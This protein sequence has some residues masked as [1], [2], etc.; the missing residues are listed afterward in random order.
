M[1]RK[2]Y[3]C[4]SF[5]GLPAPVEEDNG[6]RELSVD[7]K[8]IVSTFTGAAGT[9]ACDINCFTGN[10]K[11]VGVWDENRIVLVKGWFNESLP[12]IA[13]KKI[14]F[15]RLDG[16]LY[17]STR[18]GL[19]YLYDKVS[20]GGYI[21]VDDYGSFAGCAQ[22]VDEF[23]KARGITAKMHSVTEAWNE[24]N[25]QVPLDTT[26]HK[27][28]AVWWQKPLEGEG[29]DSGEGAPAVPAGGG[30]DDAPA[31]TSHHHH[32][33]L[34]PKPTMSSHEQRHHHRTEV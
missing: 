29:G 10:L 7:G 17:V 13:V 21:Y 32:R 22:A 19:K 26:L 31:S 2:F 30:D 6:A 23:R 1:E 5:E 27:F 12:K 14:S 15:L 24:N 25:L 28:E 18:D 33:H 20:P 11:G 16:D 34:G 8:P 3:A 9:F 4:D